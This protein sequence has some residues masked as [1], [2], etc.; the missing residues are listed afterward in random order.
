M[1]HLNTSLLTITEIVPKIATQQIPKLATD[2]QAFTAIVRDEEGAT[3]YTATLT[4]AG[5]FTKEPALAS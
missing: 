2:T 1:H 5:L 3:V 4:F